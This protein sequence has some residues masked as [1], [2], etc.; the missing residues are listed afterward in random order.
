MGIT[1]EY[2]L[3]YEDLPLVEIADTAGVDM[4]LEVGQPNRN[5]TPVLTVHAK[6][7][8]SEVKDALKESDVVESYSVVD[9]QDSLRRYRVLPTADHWEKFKRGLG[10]EA[11]FEALSETSSIVERIR[12]TADGWVQKRRFADRDEFSGYCEFWRDAGGS[13]SVRRVTD[14]EATDNA[15]KMLTDSQRTAL[16][17]AHEMG[18]FE[19]PRRV[20]LSEVADELGVSATSASERL[21]R[22]NERLV[23]AFLYSY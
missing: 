3:K 6:V 10:G 4:E 12:V 13:V 22:G 1:V 16:R 11:G 23:E 15:S 18:Y 14:T 5:E 19:V 2:L 7:E 17:K 8:N 20:S 9:R 21:R